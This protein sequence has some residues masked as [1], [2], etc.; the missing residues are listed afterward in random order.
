M[1]GWVWNNETVELRGAFITC[2][3]VGTLINY[4]L[5]TKIT[6]IGNNTIA[7]ARERDVK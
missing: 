1:G 3:Q 7:C 4:V 5:Y 2:Q 6:Y